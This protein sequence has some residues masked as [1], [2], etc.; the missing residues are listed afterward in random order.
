MLHQ[1]GSRYIYDIF[2]FS[3]PTREEILQFTEQDNKHHPREESVLDVRTHFEP[4]ETF[5]YTHFSSCHHYGVKRWFIKGEALRL[6]RTNSSKTLF[7]ENKLQITP[8]RERVPK[9]LYSKDRLLEKRRL[10]TGT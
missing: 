10:R 4:A 8:S 7:E 5:H 9:G 3:N 1:T 2:S 6:P